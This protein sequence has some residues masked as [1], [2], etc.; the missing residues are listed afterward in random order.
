MVLRLR[1]APHR[2]GYKGLGRVVFTGGNSWGGGGGKVERVDYDPTETGVRA[3][4]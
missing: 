3:T 4:Q 1:R 2:V